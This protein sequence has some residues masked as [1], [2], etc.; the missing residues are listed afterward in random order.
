[1]MVRP[2]LLAC[3]ALMVSFPSHGS[4]LPELGGSVYV[5]LPEG[6]KKTFIQAHTSIPLLVLDESIKGWSSD[7]IADFQ[8]SEK[9][10]TWSFKATIDVRLLA[11][12]I[13][14]CLDVQQQPNLR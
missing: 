1:M 3:L 6:I 12:A 7:L 8:F 9:S 5:D 10:N 2:W 4:R 13:N 11:R 14:R